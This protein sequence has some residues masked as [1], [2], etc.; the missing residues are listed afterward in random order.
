M[1][2]EMYNELIQL[3]FDGRGMYEDKVRELADGRVYTGKQAK[4]NN[5]T[6]EVGTF[7]DTL[8][9]LQTTE[10]LED[11]EVFEYNEK[12]VLLSAFMQDAQNIFKSDESE[13]VEL[14]TSLEHAEKPRAL[15]LYNN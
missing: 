14:I 8:T 7:E 2:N 5:L 11:A 1:D 13:L 4:E 9:D 10:G 6:D 12:Q 3:I 15:Y